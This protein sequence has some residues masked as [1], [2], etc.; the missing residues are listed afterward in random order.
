M[1]SQ[2]GEDNLELEQ[3]DDPESGWT[4]FLSLAS[5]LVLVLTI[6]AITVLFYF[7]R[8]LEV[9][10]KVI[11]QPA[12]QLSEL[13]SEQE[14]QLEGYSIYQVI[15]IGGTEEDA[16]DFIRIPIER[17]MEIINAEAR[18]PQ[19][20]SMDNQSADGSIVLRDTSDRE[21]DVRQ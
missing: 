20:S 18:E 8:D 12:L 5:L 17:A 19:T 16:E 3:I 14:A 1:S 10:K 13:R 15:P 2:L 4:W 21:G 7:F 9:D 6:V 11:D